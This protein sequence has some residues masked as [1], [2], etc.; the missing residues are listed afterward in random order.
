MRDALEARY[1]DELKYIRRLGVE[2]ARERP[3]IADRLL[4]DRE[5]GE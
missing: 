5:T 3:K 2:F 1:E 4:L